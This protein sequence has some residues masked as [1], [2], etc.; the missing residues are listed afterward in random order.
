[1][2]GDFKRSVHL[3]IKSDDKKGLLAKMSETF[4]DVGV[5]IVHADA[6]ATPDKRGAVS[7]FEIEVT[8]AKQLNEAIRAIGNIPGVHVVE[9]V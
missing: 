2:R 9:R 4:A 3:R 8:D 6:R 7:T 1:V 5:N